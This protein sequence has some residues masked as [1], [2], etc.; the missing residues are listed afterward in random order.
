MI[1]TTNVTAYELDQA[2]GGA[3]DNYVSQ[4]RLVVVDAPEDYAL[5]RVP[6]TTDDILYDNAVTVIRY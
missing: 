4:T 1:I 2:M 6:W 5:N 3:P